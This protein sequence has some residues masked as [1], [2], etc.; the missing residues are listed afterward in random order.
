M[1]L[2]S[3]VQEGTNLDLDIRDQTLIASS[4][5]RKKFSA[6]FLIREAKEYSSQ[7]TLSNPRQQTCFVKL[8]VR[9]KALIDAF[10]KAVE[11]N[12]TPSGMADFWKRLT[13]D[14]FYFPD[15]VCTCQLCTR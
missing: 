14:G 10:S 9:V 13:T 2:S 12:D 3:I 15:D 5:L 4:S 7:E 1:T 11:K 8:K 6:L